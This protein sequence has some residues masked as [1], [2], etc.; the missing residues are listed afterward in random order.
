MVR[1]GCRT[2]EA[3]R[4]S[5]LWRKKDIFNKNSRKTK[6]GLQLN[7]STHQ[8]KVIRTGVGVMMW[9]NSHTQSQ[10]FTLEEH[11]QHHYVQSLCSQALGGEK[12]QRVRGL[13]KD[14][15]NSAELEQ[16]P[17]VHCHRSMRDRELHYHDHGF[18]YI[19]RCSD[20]SKGPFGTLASSW[21][22]GFLPPG[23][24]MLIGRWLHM[25][26]PT[27]TISTSSNGNWW[28]SLLIT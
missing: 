16:C 2:P 14:R 6:K 4:K 17:T 11:G 1:P 3:Y 18:I 21:S 27:Y 26:L 9:Q 20:T 13:F 12:E 22:T 7:R 28:S 10:W 19:R 8:K 5:F 23:H 15:L 24:T 25:Y